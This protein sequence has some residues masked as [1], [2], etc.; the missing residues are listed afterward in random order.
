LHGNLDAL[1][2]SRR[3]GRSNRSQAFVL[4]LLARLA[5]LRFVFQPFVVKEYLFAGSPDEILVAINAPDWAV[6]ILA[7]VDFQ[8]LGGFR[9][10]HVPTPSVRLPKHHAGG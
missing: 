9:L 4:S 3:L 8:Y 7:F 5:P 10:C 1:S 6:L 2:H